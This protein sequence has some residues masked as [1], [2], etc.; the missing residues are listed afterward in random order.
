MK[1]TSAQY[2]DLF[3]GEQSTHEFRDN[4][5]LAD[6][7][8]VDGVDEYVENLV[9]TNPDWFEDEDP[10]DV[11]GALL[12]E[13]MRQHHREIRGVMFRFEDGQWIWYEDGGS[14]VADAVCNQ[15][16]DATDNELWEGYAASPKA[17]TN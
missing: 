14:G 7:G 12:S 6:V 17:S 9:L 1:K 16:P 3:V 13:I 5:I 2:W 10:E 15:D 4:L 11:K 8:T